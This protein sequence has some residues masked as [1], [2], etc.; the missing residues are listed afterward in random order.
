MCH[1][2]REN[3]WLEIQRG[4]EYI[5]KALSVDP[6]FYNAYLYEKLL[7]I[8]QGKIDRDPRKRKEIAAKQQQAQDRCAWR[9][10]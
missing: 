5:F 6:E 1:D 10:A 9:R 8:E 7:W 2:T 3:P 4:F